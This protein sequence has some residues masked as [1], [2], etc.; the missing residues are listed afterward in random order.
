MIHTAHLPPDQLGTI[1][2]GYRRL[3]PLNFAD[4]DV[5]WGAILWVNVAT[6]FIDNF[7]WAE[8]DAHERLSILRDGLPE[9]LLR[10]HAYPPPTLP[11]DA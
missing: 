11:P 10:I 4:D 3:V 1:L 6:K 2:D 8:C 7:T 5:R 9:I